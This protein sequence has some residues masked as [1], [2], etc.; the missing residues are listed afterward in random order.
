MPLNQGSTLEIEKYITPQELLTFYGKDYKDLEIIRILNQKFPVK[1][2][3]SIKSLQRLKLK[4]N[5]TKCFQL[6]EDQR[7][8]VVKDAIATVSCKI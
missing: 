2:G 6:N 4:W 3:I 8:L 7:K 1:R 5:I